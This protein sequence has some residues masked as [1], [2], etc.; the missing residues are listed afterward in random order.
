[1][2]VSVIIPTRN[3]LAFLREAIASVEMQSYPEWDLIV[4]DDASNDGTSD[5]L[6]TLNTPRVRVI[7]MEH[8]AERSAARNRGLQGA[9]AEWVLFLDDDDRLK[10]RALARLFAA[11]EEHPHAVASVGARVVFSERGYSPRSLHPR[12]QHKLDARLDVLFMWV[13]AQGQALI[14]KSAL[15]RAGGW[16][17]HMALGEDHELWLR[18]VEFGPV[19]TIPDT[20]VEVRSHPG[21][22]LQTGLPGRTRDFRSAF[23]Q[24]LPAEL[25]GRGERAYEAFRCNKA[26]QTAFRMGDY[27]LSLKLYTRIIRRAPF[28]LGSPLS[29]PH[30]L[31]HFFKSLGGSVFGASVVDLVRRVKRWGTRRRSRKMRKMDWRAIL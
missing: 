17:G 9:V 20:V 7:R 2:N 1:M 16:K 5:Y 24:K 11:L 14:R 8:H 27:R 12:F 21:Q 15:I 6:R 26:G 29:R 22:S 4:V 30:I 18:L 10:P 13:P 31:W 25:R 28:L 19:I 3:R 23:V